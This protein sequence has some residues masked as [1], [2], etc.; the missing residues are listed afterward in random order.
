MSPAGGSALGGKIAQSKLQ[1]YLSLTVITNFATVL[2]NSLTSTNNGYNSLPEIKS[3][4][5]CIF[6]LSAK[7][8]S[9][10]G[11]QFTFYIDLFIPL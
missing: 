1:N 3:L 10:S 2:A 8:E 7:S 9:A 11:G 4:L 5:F 6:N